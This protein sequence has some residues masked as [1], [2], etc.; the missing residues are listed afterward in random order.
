MARLW[1]QTISFFYTYPSFSCYS[2]AAKWNIQKSCYVKHCK[3]NLFY[4]FFA[5]IQLKGGLK[6][7]KKSPIVID[8]QGFTLFFI[9]F[10]W[11]AW[12]SPYRVT[13]LIFKTL[14]FLLQAYPMIYPTNLLRAFAVVCSWRILWTKIVVF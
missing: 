8:Y 14:Y 13:T 7:I 4:L 1:K 12:D 10:Q 6:E 3:S 11:S 2:I 5:V 9:L